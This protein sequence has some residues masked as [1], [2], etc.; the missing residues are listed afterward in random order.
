MDLALKGEPL[1]PDVVAWSAH[2][3]S[4]TGDDAASLALALQKGNSIATLDEQI[5]NAARSA[6]VLWKSHS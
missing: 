1:N 2:E 3:H 5:R 4:L 6:R